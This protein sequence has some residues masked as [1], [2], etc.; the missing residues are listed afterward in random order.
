MKRLLLAAALLAAPM[1]AHAQ[2]ALRIGL[3]EDPDILDP[4]LGS[5]YVGRIVYAAMCDK[6]FDLDTKLNIVPQLATGFRY[7]SPTSLVLTL[8]PGVTFH[9]GEKFDAEAAKYS[10]NRHLNLKGSMRAGEI[11]AIET[12]EII[13]PL[14]IRLKLKNP[15]AQLLAQLTDR[16]GIMVSPKAAEALGDKFGTAPVCAGAYAFESRLPQDRITLKRYP[17]HWNAKE[18]HFDTVT[19]MPIPNSPVRLANLQAGSLDLVEFI[20]PT[21]IPAVQ[22]DPKLK[23][24]ES[25][26]LGYTGIN[27]NVNNGPAAQTV[28]GQN[29]LVRQA[30]EAAIDRKA[31]IDVVFNGMFTPTIQANTPSSPFFVPKFA[32][33]GRD[34]AKAKALLAQAGVKLPVPVELTITI[35]PE[36]VQVAEVIQSMV[37][38][39]GFDLKLKTMEFASSLQAGYKGDFQAYMI[40]WSG[41]SDADGNMWALM[42]SKGTFNYGRH[43]NPAMDKL[44]DD[45]R[46]ETDVAKRRDIY[47]Q[48]WDIQRQDLPLI[49]LYMGKNIVGMKKNLDGFQQ[50]PD[51]LIRLTDVKLTK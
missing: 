34:L 5:S 37:A 6:L 46:L 12:I 11:N 27:I 31:I 42:H 45:A 43:S 4:T 50:V 32:P 35:S 19:Y 39:A 33:P 3:R 8:R 49:Y 16:A 25:D 26:A 18:F 44:L 29:P 9:D 28:L 17:G 38:E 2:D 14:T 21:D 24:M 51:G 47:S 20:A 10:L 7:E 30:F 41:R 48:V 13:D 36:T 1:V 22:K 23:L 40:G 15:A